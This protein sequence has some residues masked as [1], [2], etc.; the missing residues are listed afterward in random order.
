MTYKL[1]FIPVAKKEWDKLG[2]TI[3]EQF[4][5]KL[6]ERL[7]NP[8]ISKNAISGGKNLYKIKLKSAGYRL[9]YQVDDNRIVVLILAIGQRNRN[10]VYNKLFSRL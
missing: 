7:N 2:A 1:E 4:K 10:E 9:V 6:A 8:H 3:K 5:K